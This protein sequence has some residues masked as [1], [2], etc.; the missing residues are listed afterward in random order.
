MAVYNGDINLEIV[1]KSVAD[2][3]VVGITVKGLSSTL[4]LLSNNEMVKI[5]HTIKVSDYMDIPERESGFDYTFDL[6]FD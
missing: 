3:D 4:D 1:A 5:A 6:I 2:N